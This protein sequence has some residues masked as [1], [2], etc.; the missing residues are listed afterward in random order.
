[1]QHVCPVGRLLVVALLPAIAPGQLDRSGLNGTITDPKGAR[2]PGAVVKANQLETG[3]ERSTQTSSQ[4]T[5][6]LDGLPTGRYTITVSKPAFADLRFEQVD[7]GVGQT[8]TLDAQLGLTGAAGGSATVLEPL[9]RLDT[10]S[11]V[12][13]APIEQAQLRDLPLNGRNWSSLT[14]LTP[15]AIDNGPSDQRTIRFA[16]HGL[17]DNDFLFDG[18]DASGVLN[19]AQ[20][21]YVRLAIPLDSIAQFQV[22]TQNFS[23][24]EGMT[25]GGQV[26]VASRS[27]TND[28]HGSVFEFF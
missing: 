10:A 16:G 17:D 23:A 14:A 22:Q 8:R 3:L 11:A 27:G 1:M 5:Y 12:L 15:G 7:Q 21:E 2:V 28:V 19:Q 18:V 24:D 25:A 13:G 26:S 9:V 6:A 4:G 20:K